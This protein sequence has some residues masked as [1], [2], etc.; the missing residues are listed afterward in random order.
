M[1]FI[2]HLFVLTYSKESAVSFFR[3]E[4]NKTGLEVSKNKSWN[5]P[6]VK[7]SKSNSD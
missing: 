6:S 1:Q 4:T 2:R 5:E 3:A 7:N